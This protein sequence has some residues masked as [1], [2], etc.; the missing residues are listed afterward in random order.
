M[1][2]KRRRFVLGVYALSVLALSSRFDGPGAGGQRSAA[3]ALS[4]LA[5]SSR[6]DGLG[7][8]G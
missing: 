3:G 2:R 5:L 6:F 1:V 4:V 7:R 8:R